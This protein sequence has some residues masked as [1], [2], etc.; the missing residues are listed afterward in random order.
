MKQ[1]HVIVKTARF[2]ANQDA[3]MEIVLR[4]K[5]AG[6]SMFEFLNYGKTLYPFYKY[7]I[8]VI[9]SGR[10]VPPAEV[11]TAPA[12]QE[13]SEEESDDDGGYLHPSLFSSSS[14]VGVVCLIAE[15][16]LI[17]I[18]YFYRRLFCHHC[19]PRSRLCQSSKT[20]RLLT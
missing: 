6:N 14:T 4:A 20:T 11:Q 12:T 16:Q 7:L 19:Q 15:K 10:W 8:R 9:K 13:E 2:L 1:F 18:E 5:Q 17:N 3:Q